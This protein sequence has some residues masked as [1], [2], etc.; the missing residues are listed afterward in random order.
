MTAAFLSN[1]RA[2]SLVSAGR[3]YDDLC[4]R[5][6]YHQA[7]MDIDTIEPGADFGEV[8]EGAVACGD[9]LLALVGPRRFSRA[10]AQRL[11]QPE[12]WVRQE[13]AM[14]LALQIPVI[15]V[16]LGGARMPRPDST[17][18]VSLCPFRRQL[19]E[20]WSRW[21]PSCEH[22]SR[23]CRPGHPRP[24]RLAGPA[25]PTQDVRAVS[26]R[27]RAISGRVDSGRLPGLSGGCPSAGAPAATVIQTIRRRIKLDSCR[28]HS[29]AELIYVPS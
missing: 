1:R 12:D 25:R 3:L 15:P 8:I 10:N 5:Y 14:A 16:L 17:S 13:I 26:F 9:V 21:A 24:D 2:D 23:H 28:W 29:R 27:G 18:R 6:G 20:R 22:R 11:Q 4:E 19:A 7:F